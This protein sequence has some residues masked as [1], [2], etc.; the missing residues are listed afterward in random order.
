MSFDETEFIAFCKEKLGSLKAPKS[1]SIE[2]NLPRSTVGKV[3]RREVRE[4][5]WSGRERAI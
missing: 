5:Y 2:A 3:L 4:R 1:V